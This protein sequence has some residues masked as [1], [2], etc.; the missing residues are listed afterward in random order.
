[1]AKVLNLEQVKEKLPR[2]L[3][4][5]VAN[6]L[7]VAGVGS[8]W[9]YGDDAWKGG[10][11]QFAISMQ[12]TQ[13]KKFRAALN[14]R[15][16]DL[17]GAGQNDIWMQT[18]PNVPVQLW[19]GTDA[20]KFSHVLKFDET[21][22]GPRG[23]GSKTSANPGTVQ[24]EKV[25]LK[26]FEELLKKSGPK[27][28]RI[29]FYGPKG[30][31]E[32]VLKP[33]YP[34]ID[35]PERIDWTK[36]FELQYNEIEST[37]RLPNNKFDVF[38]Y[39]AFMDYIVDIVLSGPHTGG[40][41]PL[42]GKISKKDSWNPADIWLVQSGSKFSET[43]KELQTCGTIRELN[44]ILKV[45]FKNNIIVGVSL[46][47]SSGKPGGLHWEL[48]NLESTL[49]N[50]PK[51]TL[52]KFKLDL[53]F[54]GGEFTKTTNEITVEDNGR[55]VG[56]MRTGSNTRA[57]GNNTYEFKATGSV[58]AMLGKLDKTL[59]LRRLKQEIQISELPTQ[60][61]VKAQRPKT[62]GDSNYN[63]WKSVVN[64]VGK[65][66]IF[67]IPNTFNLNTFPESLVSVGNG[68]LSKEE[69]ACMQIMEFAHI[70]VQVEKKSGRKGVDEMFEDFYYFAQKKGSVFGSE[71]GPFAKLS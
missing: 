1:M 20:D 34:D 14:K 18:A 63:Y 31:L 62:R 16:V 6:T 23:S 47:K 33:I 39:N 37:T 58:K 8:E 7:K 70:L 51:I 27:Y 4:N 69:S 46:K 45:A 50:L 68:E 35:H 61:T 53:P 19:Y 52:G 13:L 17:T 29:G 67:E 66:N 60:H 64:K 43:K 3:G 41:W 11:T 26:I 2:A 44:D 55:A 54:S 9:I 59:M 21:G 30:L 38:D 22:L 57:I 15:S 25:T 42:F 10:K 48:V 5:F 12:K 49:T 65:S 71:F 32:K 36:H 24:Q 56:L 28:D 40:N